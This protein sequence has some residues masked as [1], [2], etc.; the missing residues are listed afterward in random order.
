MYYV[1]KYTTAYRTAYQLTEADKTNRGLLLFVFWTR[2]E[3]DCLHIRLTISRVLR[4]IRSISTIH[5]PFKLVCRQSLS[6]LVQ[7]I[8]N[9]KPLLVSRCND[10]V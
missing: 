7:K 6:A 9:N 4:F 3:S 1:V 8:N 10:K 5:P 2:A